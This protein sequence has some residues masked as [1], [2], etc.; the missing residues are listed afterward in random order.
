MDRR[1]RMRRIAGVGGRFLIIG[2]ISTLI[3]IGVFNFLVY[4]LGWDFVIAKIAASL[5]ALVNAYFGNREWAFRHRDRRGRTS[6]I[7]LFLGTNLACTLF[8]AAL[9]WLGV[10]GA[11]AVLGHDPGAAVVNIVNLA[12]IGI[13]VVIRFVLYHGVVFRPA[14][15]AER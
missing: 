6:E 12:S 5:V 15:S 13:V 4:A 3:E 11:R 14:R 2:G 1:S 10:E 9:V 7:V 8:G